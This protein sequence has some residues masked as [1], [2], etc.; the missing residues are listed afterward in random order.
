MNE[1]PFIVLK[2]LLA[3]ETWQAFGD[4]LAQD[5]FTN[6]QFRR[7][8]GH[9]ADLHASTT[10]DLNVPALVCEIEVKYAEKPDLASELAEAARSLDTVEVPP[11]DVLRRQLCEFVSREMA[12]QAATQI[13]DGRAQKDFDVSVPAQLLARAVE[14]GSRVDSGFLEFDTAPLP[15][16]VDP[17]PGLTGLGLSSELD[18]ALGGGVGDGEL[19]V[20]VGPPGRG[21]TS[22]LCA[23]GAR[24][25]KKGRRVLHITLEISGPR[26]I[27]RYDSALCRRSFTDL[28]AQ[29]ARAEA[30]RAQVQVAGGSFTVRDLSY[31]KIS[32]DDIVSM[33]RRR[34]QNK[35]PVDLVIVDY[36][37][38]ISPASKIKYGDARHSYAAAIREMRAA[39]VALQVPIISAWQINREGSDAYTVSQKDISECWGLNEDSDIILSLNQT[40]AERDESIMRIGILKQRDSTYRGLVYLRCDFSNMDI[41]QAE[42]HTIAEEISVGQTDSI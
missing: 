16:A 34:R 20:F 15:G 14:V 9:I 13:V 40:D 17:R 25:A 1:L 24:A 33:V 36:L 35:Q 6:M 7:L 26:V 3:K 21:K 37:K 4:V 27:W 41:R 12:L 19:C 10:A 38:H 39:A 11:R 8:Y 30:G 23:V 42:Q 5:S 2:S 22:I 29:P 18:S 28:S 31:S 32:A